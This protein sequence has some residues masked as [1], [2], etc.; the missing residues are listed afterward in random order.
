MERVDGTAGG[1]GGDQD[2][3]SFFLSHFPPLTHHGA[4][5]PDSEIGGWAAAGVPASVLARLLAP[6][7]APSAAASR[8]LNPSSS[9]GNRGVSPRA[10]G[11]VCGHELETSHSRTELCLPPAACSK[12]SP[13]SSHPS[14]RARSHGEGRRSALDFVRQARPVAPVLAPWSTNFSSLPCLV[15]TRA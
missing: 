12:S 8:G 7:T 3:L 4:G 14:A 2:S 6:W 1:R 13:A 15:L 11:L 10:G 9:E 5:R